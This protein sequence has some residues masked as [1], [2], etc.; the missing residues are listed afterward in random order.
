[1]SYN[2][3]DNQL[4]LE[5]EEDKKDERVLLLLGFTKMAEETKVVVV[6]D[7]VVVVGHDVCVRVGHIAREDNLSGSVELVSV[8]QE[9][10]ED[11]ADKHPSGSVELHH[12]ALV[13]DRAIGVGLLAVLEHGRFPLV[14]LARTTSFH[15]HIRA[16]QHGDTRKHVKTDNGQVT[17]DRNVHEAVLESC[18]K[19]RLAELAHI[20]ILPL[21]GVSLALRHTVWVPGGPWFVHEI[22][23]Q[24]SFPRGASTAAVCVLRTCWS[25]EAVKPA[26][27]QSTRGAVKTSSAQNPG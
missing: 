11:A 3:R 1:M 26:R 27:S 23:P 20:D 18:P 7:R 13:L 6:L 17:Q 15:T 10:E 25:G 21:R 22:K 12:V 2:S 8:Q 16:R 19:V 24:P 9:G 5:S 4:T 14:A